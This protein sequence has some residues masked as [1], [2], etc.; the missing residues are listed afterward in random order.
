MNSQLISMTTKSA[1]PEGGQPTG[2]ERS[3]AGGEAAYFASRV[4][5]LGRDV[6]RNF[7]GT[8]SAEPSRLL[9]VFARESPAMIVGA[10]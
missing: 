4:Q 9:P 1:Q 8:S 2:L 10:A 3:K 6:Y 7:T 5:M